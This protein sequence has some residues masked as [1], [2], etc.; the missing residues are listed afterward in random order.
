MEHSGVTRNPDI[1]I[2]SNRIQTPQQEST[3]KSSEKRLDKFMTNLAF[4]EQF[5]QLEQEKKILQNKFSSLGKDFFKDPTNEHAKL[6][7]EADPQLRKME[8]QNEFQNLSSELKQLERQRGSQ[9]QERNQ[10]IRNRMGEILSELPKLQDPN[11]ET[12]DRFSQVSEYKE[13]RDEIAQREEAL[14]GHIQDSNITRQEKLGM[15]WKATAAKLNPL[16][17]VIMENLI[18]PATKDFTRKELSKNSDADYAVGIEDNR[19]WINNEV[20]AGRA[21]AFIV[22]T[23]DHHQIEG[24]LIKAPST[25][26]TSSSANDN[27]P[28]TERPTM[29]YVAGNFE[30]MDTA[31]SLANDY[32]Q[33]YDINVVIY[34]P[35]GIGG[36]LGREHST[37]EAVTDAETVIKHTLKEYCGN[38][39][40]NLGVHGFSLGG[41]ITATVLKRMVKENPEL[42]GKIGLY[43]N[44]HSFTSLQGFLKGAV[45]GITQNEKILQKSEKL[46][47]VMVKGIGI[48][49]LDTKKALQKDIAAKVIINTAE[50]DEV[51]Q[52]AARLGRHFKN[53]E[54][55]TLLSRHLMHGD[56]DQI[57]EKASSQQGDQ[58]IDEVDLQYD[59]LLREW[60]RTPKQT[61]QETG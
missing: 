48:N 46:F 35:R 55:I 13:K 20:K 4:K 32:A 7:Q 30:S 18:H 8:L 34:N 53:T 49:T 56:G 37:K 29:V 25:Y 16:R 44:T 61:E 21:E 60:A 11:F 5:V 31:A 14:K 9:T 22:H 3:N 23:S 19:K 15:I 39:P 45:G 41:G 42:K 2:G 28:K 58:I 50:N 59:S 10:E 26:A 47:R 12:L 33:K 57:I 24:T 40:S 36:S 6:K 38:D 54:K 17:Q 43:T 51:M 27:A 1:T 52:E